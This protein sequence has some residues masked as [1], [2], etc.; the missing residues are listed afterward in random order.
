VDQKAMQAKVNEMLITAYKDP[1][2]TKTTTNAVMKLS[3]ASGRW[4]ID[5]DNTTDSEALVNALMGNLLTIIP[6]AK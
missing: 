4:D 6:R 1:N 5:M 2:A 3:R